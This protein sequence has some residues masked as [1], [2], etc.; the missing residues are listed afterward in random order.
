MDQWMQKTLAQIC[1]FQD[2]GSALLSL[3]PERS[4]TKTPEAETIAWRVR[5]ATF[6][7][8]QGLPTTYYSDSR[9][10]ESGLSMLGLHTV[11][12]L[13]VLG[14]LE[15]DLQ[16]GGIPGVGHQARAYILGTLLD[17]AD[18]LCRDEHALSAIAIGGAVL[19]TYLRT[20]AAARSSSCAEGSSKLHSIGELNSKLHDAEVY[21]HTTFG[22]INTWTTLRDDA[23][24]GKHTDFSKAS[25]QAYLMGIREL[26]LP[27][28]L[29]P[30]LGIS[31]YD[32]R[33]FDSSEE[34]RDVRQESRPGKYRPTNRRVRSASRRC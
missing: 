11:R 12:V 2:C 5:V 25:I 16:S 4:K 18:Q 14:G 6:L 13:A 7:Q 22:D 8:Q 3:G 34:E 23:N 32:G 21:D 10:S 15:R 17:Q 30:L 24:H 26:C 27:T 19:E 28:R 29:P 31:A 33:L 1:E 9:L 20:L